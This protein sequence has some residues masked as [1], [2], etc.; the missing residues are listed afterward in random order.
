MFAI[1]I[2]SSHA[3]G[4][5][6]FFRALNIVDFLKEKNIPYIVFVNNNETTLNMLKN[7]SIAFE[8]VDLYDFTSKWEIKLLEKYPIDIW[9]NDR[10]DTDA[11]HVRMLKSYPVSVITFDDRGTGAALSDLNVA[12]MTFENIDE[13]AG[14]KIFTGLEYLILNKQIDVYKRVRKK[15]EKIVV[16]L[17][18]SDTY[19]VTIKVINIL[20]KYKK[21][22]TIILGPSF[23]HWKSLDNVLDDNF[24][25]KFAVPSLIEELHNY[26]IAITGGGVTP[27]EAN[28]AG[29]PCIIIANEIHEI[30]IAKYLD[31]L[32]TSIFA[33]YY[34]NM[35]EKMFNNEFQIEKMS[36]K[37]LSLIKTDALEKIYREMI[38]C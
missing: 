18:G 19:G 6:H 30:Q 2:E 29:L 4:M 25:V 34:Q 15:C 33:G 11:R 35:N 20:K 36:E 28:A 17:G 27:I 22:A 9:I 5:G 7:R 37:G 31:S 26:D 32:G 24:V 21:K 16:T 1:C 8:I 10:L 12:A 38:L 14:R 3:R 23:I 13:L